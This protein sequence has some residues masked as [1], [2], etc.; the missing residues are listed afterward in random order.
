[1]AA[2]LHEQTWIV[3]AGSIVTACGVP[4]PP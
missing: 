1:M 2:R 3:W 4:A